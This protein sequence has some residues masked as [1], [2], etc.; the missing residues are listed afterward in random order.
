MNM[1]GEVALVTGAS[2]GLGEATARALAKSGAAVMLA[3]RSAEQIAVIASEIRGFGG[4]AEAMA[5]DVADYASVAQVARK[6]VESFGP[7]SILIANAGVIEPISHVAT[8]DPAE[9]ARSVAIN[10]VG[11]YNSVRSVLPGMLERGR[12]TIVN[13]SSGAANHALEG[14]SAYCAGKAGFTSFSNVLA[15][16]V[17]DRGV[18]VFALS[19]GT[20]DTDMQGAI[21]ASGMNPV[22][23]IPR[24]SLRPVAHAV[25]AILYLCSASADDLAG[26]VVT[27]NDEAFRKR[28]GV[29]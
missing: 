10:L 16:E 21:R 22:S 19:P 23:K 8:S 9:W 27:M 2:R 15:H 14:W 7:V 13:V 1:Q 17:G 28:I 26:G 11:G 18:R 12:G 3:A 4:R 29:K 24:E 25:D 20:I 6:A 5:C